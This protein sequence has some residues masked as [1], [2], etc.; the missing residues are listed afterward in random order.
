MTVDGCTSTNDT[1][2][3]LASGRAG[4]PDPAG[5][6]AAVAA[7]CGDLATQMVGDAEGHTKVVGVWVTGAASGDDA[8]R[9]AR[10]VAESQLVKCSWFGEDPY[11]GRIASDLG[12]A[13]VALDPAGL[14]IAYGGTVVSRG[15]VSIDHDRAAVADHMAGEHLDVHCDLGVGDGAA[16]VLTNDLAYGY[17]DENKGTS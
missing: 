7:A 4:A 13:G 8:R 9:A 12:T 3:L 17:I 2:L 1:V 11:W 5:F 16:R 14:T 6:A 10:K 15:C